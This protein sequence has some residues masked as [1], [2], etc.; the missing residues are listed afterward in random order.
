MNL[1]LEPPRFDW[2]QGTVEMGSDDLIELA[3]TVLGDERPIPAPARNGYARGWEIRRDGARSAVVFEGGIHDD[4]HIVATGEDAP[5]LAR[6]LRGSS[7]SH[8]V[9]RADVCVDTDTPGA[10]EG[11]FGAL[12]QIARTSNLKANLY[13]NPDSTEDGAT[14]YLGSKSSEVRARLYEKGKQ[15]P[16]AERP[17]WV[18]FEIQARPQK[19]RKAWTATASEWDVLGSAHW[20]RKFA[21]ETLSG[22]ATA[23]PTRS[24]RVS[25]LE[26]ALRALSHQYGRR[27]L[28]LLERHNGDVGSFGLELAL[29]AA[30]GGRLPESGRG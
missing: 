8:R 27:M 26:G 2:Y 5:S 17:H 21:S 24:E 15:L 7:R 30:H 13:H 22:A 20:S 1:A 9:S 11:L 6:F 12:R 10:F 19:D 23:P 25:D 16:E 28:E 4:P 3:A 18:R 29:R 14:Y